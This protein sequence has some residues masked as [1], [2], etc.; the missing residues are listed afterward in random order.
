MARGAV[1]RAINKS[2][3]PL[4]RTTANIGILQTEVYNRV[5]FQGHRDAEPNRPSVDGQQYVEYTAQ[6]IIRKVSAPVYPMTIPI[7]SHTRELSWAG[8]SPIRRPIIEI[9]LSM[10]PG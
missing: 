4:R 8:T 7:L 1:Y 3:G 9:S 10:T 2:Q 6:W 5:G